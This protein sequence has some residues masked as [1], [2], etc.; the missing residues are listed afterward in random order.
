M[1]KPTGKK[2]I[3]GSR[4]IAKAAGRMEICGTPDRGWICPV[5]SLPA[6]ARMYRVKRIV[7]RFTRFGI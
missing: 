2:A 3:F 7:K 4:R 1:K 5:K 6:A